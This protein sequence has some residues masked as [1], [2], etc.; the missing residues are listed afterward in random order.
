MAGSGYV[1]AEGLIVSAG[2]DTYDYVNDQRRL[3]ASIRSVVPVTDRSAGD[4]VSTAM[5]SDGRAVADTNPLIAFN[6]STKTLDWKDS[7]GW[8]GGFEHAEFTTGVQTMTTAVNYSTGSMT[9]DALNSVNNGAVCNITGGSND[10]LTVVTAGLYA[11]TWTASMTAAA[12]GSFMSIRDGSGNNYSSN[13]FPATALANTVTAPNIYLLAGK[14][15]T[16][17]CAQNSGSDKSW[18]HRVRITKIH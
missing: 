6:I 16:F 4:T 11:V 5:A 9:L 10:Q 17:T 15:I 13:D 8:H 18:T 7:T 2:G 1:T 12:A 3:A 14:V